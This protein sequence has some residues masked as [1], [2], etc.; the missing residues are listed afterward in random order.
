MRGPWVWRS[1]GAPLTSRRTSP[2][3]DATP[4]SGS[5]ATLVSLGSNIEP[6]I[7]LPQAVEEI[8]RRF[9]IT[10][11]S[12]V[13]AAEAVGAP[14][15]PTFLNAAVSFTTELALYNLEAGIKSSLLGRTLQLNASVFA[16]RHDNAQVRTSFQLSPGDLPDG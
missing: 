6:A 3:P 13:Y 11:V 12:R 16:S 14:G 9:R 2:H 1:R 7:H 4:D 10:G 5:R 8:G 15:A